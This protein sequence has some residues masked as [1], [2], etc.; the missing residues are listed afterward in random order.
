MSQWST[1]KGHDNGSRSGALN[2][3]NGQG[4]TKREGVVDVSRHA[5]EGGV[6]S[7]QCQLGLFVGRVLLKRHLGLSTLRLGK[8]ILL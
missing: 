1:D 6:E 2:N 8:T 3:T 7:Q 4:H 5:E